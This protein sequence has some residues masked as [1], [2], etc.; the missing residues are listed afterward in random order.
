[1]ENHKMIENPFSSPNGGSSWDRLVLG[2][3]IL[4]GVAKVNVSHTMTYDIVQPRGRQLA[5]VRPMGTNPRTINVELTVYDAESFDEMASILKELSSVSTGREV[6]PYQ[7]SHPSPNNMG[8][9]EVVIQAINPGN[10]SSEE[11]WIIQFDFLE[12]VQNP[13]YMKVSKNPWRNEVEKQRHRRTFSKEPT[14]GEIAN[15]LA[16]ANVIR[17]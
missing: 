16:T 8:I 11:G 3:W 17:Q 1:M 10:P 15:A 6:A 7:I 2:R 13:N 9:K 5:H 14:A 12:F 4:P